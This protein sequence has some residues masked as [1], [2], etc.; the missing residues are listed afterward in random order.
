MRR[1]NRFRTATTAV[2]AA[3][4]F[5]RFVLDVEEEIRVSALG[6]DGKLY[7]LNAIEPRHSVFALKEK[8]HSTTD[9]K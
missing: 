2:L 6:A 8:L 5:E 7:A 3:K 9:S 4:R 1:S